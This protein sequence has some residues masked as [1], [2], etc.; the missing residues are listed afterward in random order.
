MRWLR[1]IGIGALSSG[2]NVSG[3]FI[4][5]PFSDS[6]FDGRPTCVICAQVVMP[7]ADVRGCT[8]LCRRSRRSWC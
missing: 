3:L 7:D 1:D 8:R 5:G 6:A 2:V 4:I